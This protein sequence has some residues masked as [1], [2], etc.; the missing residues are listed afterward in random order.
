MGLGLKEK[1][2]LD[3]DPIRTKR[4]PKSTITLR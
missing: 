4:T 1:Y 2:L 3:L